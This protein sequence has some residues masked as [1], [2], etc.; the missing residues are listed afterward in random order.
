MTIIKTQRKIQVGRVWYEAPPVYELRDILIR[1]NRLYG[2]RVAV[3]WRVRPQDKTVQERTYREFSRDVVAVQSW[4]SSHLPKGSRIALVGDNSYLWMVVWLAVASGFG[5]IVPIDRLLSMHE[6]KAILRRSGAPMLIYDAAWHE[7]IGDLMEDAPELQWRAVMDRGLMNDEQRQTLRDEI[8]NDPKLS[9]LDDVLS[10]E[11]S[12]FSPIN[13]P[14]SKSSQDVSS[15]V[16]PASDKGNLTDVELPESAPNDALVSSYCKNGEEDYGLLPLA[17]V[18]DDAAILFTSGTSATSKAVILTN[19]CIA[20]DLRALLG[21]VS[22]MDPLQTLSILPL[23]HAFEN[24]CGFLTVMTLGGTIHHNDGLRYIGRNLKEYK[25]QL[26]V[27]VPAILDA[28]KRTILREAEKQGRLRKLKIGLALSTLLYKLGIDKRRVIF[29]DVLDQLGGQFKY[30]I[31]GAAPVSRDTLY[32]FRAIGIEILAG[33]GLTEASPVVGGGNTKVNRYG[34]TGEPLAGVEVAIDDDGSGTGEILVRSDIVM[35][36]YLDDPE[37]TAEA[38]DE[39]GW[40]HTADI[41]R[42]TRH[43]SL[44]ITGRSKSM[45]VLANGKKVF[46]EEIEALLNQDALIRDALVFGHK[47]ASGDIVVTAKLVLDRQ[48]L[49]D[50]L[51]REPTEDDYSNAVEALIAKVNR[52]LPSFKVIRSYFYSFQD[53]VKTTTLKVRRHIEMSRLDEFI[54]NSKATWQQLRGKNIDLMMEHQQ[55]KK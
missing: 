49:Q 16:E 2:D 23:H 22:F 6:V 36:G 10:C 18:E 3:R 13:F 4:L 53:M 45:I 40:L 19:K 38:I 50:L 29:R 39:D 24:T 15:S 42:W 14:I 27:A 25:V 8:A 21:S 44:K 35:K 46:P 47:S 26:T 54:R 34:T 31:C 12:A 32:F 37:A 28:M 43:G 7:K 55:G 17:S 52:N 30:V 20:A 5:V 11:Q 1:G 51:Q 33:Y 48:V 9:L 41:G